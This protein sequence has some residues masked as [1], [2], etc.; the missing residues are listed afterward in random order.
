[1]EF[2]QSEANFSENLEKA[3]LQLAESMRFAYA[4]I[5]ETGPEKWV[6]EVPFPHQ[7]KLNILNNMIKWHI[8]PDREEYE[9]AA[10]LKRALDALANLT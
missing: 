10:L 6:R 7:K 9:K 2:D 5:E 3:E 4:T 8:D 1:M